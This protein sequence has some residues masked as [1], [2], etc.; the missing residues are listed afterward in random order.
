MNERELAVT[1]LTEILNDGA[2]NNIVLRRIFNK[3]KLLT[4]IQRAFITEI[5]NGTLRNIILIDYVIDEFSKTKTKKMKPFILYLLRIS[6]Y[7]IMFMDKVPD[8]AVCNE[9]VNLSKKRGFRNLSGFIN[10]VL[11]NIARSITEIK[12][13][14]EATEPVK[15]LSVKYSYPS[16]IIEYWLSEFDYET[17]KKMCINNNKA[18]KVSI[19]VNTLKTDTSSIIELFEKEGIKAKAGTVKDNVYIS[20]SADITKTEPYKNGLFHVMDESA[21]LA[22]QALNPEKGMRVM[23]VC[24]A[25]GGKSFY[26]AYLMKDIGEIISRDIY[27]HKLELISD[28]RNRLGLKSIK[29]ELKDAAAYYENDFESFDRVIVDAPCSGLGLVRKKPDIKYTKTMEEVM[30]LAKLQR[31]ILGI[32]QS[33]VK[34]GG[35]LVYSTCTVS[36]K[37]NVENAEWFLSNYPFEKISSKQIFPAENGKDG[38]FIAVFKRKEI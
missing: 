13:P 22:V 32:C 11:R 2:Y 14:D 3:N 31:K 9:A 35:I 29:I 18:P 7:Q 16:W 23:D 1:A 33:Y 6:V 8:S 17:V 19:C 20:K 38:F 15:F 34:K 36:S 30:E 37:E 25:P 5:V 10:G 28:G 12:Y 27:E 4:D 24:A 26:C 21:M